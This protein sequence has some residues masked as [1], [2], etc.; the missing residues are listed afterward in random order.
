[1]IEII[2][3][4]VGLVSRGIPE[5]INMWKAR[6]EHKQQI[7]LMRVQLEI[8]EKLASYKLEE[9]RDTN[10]T[11]EA[12]EAMKAQADAVRQQMELTGIQWVDAW[13]RVIR[14]GT[15]SLFVLLYLLT[16]V[17]AAMV[18]FA[19]GGGA[20]N[21]LLAIWSDD[22]DKPVLIAMLN[23]WFAGRVLDHVKR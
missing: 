13:N 23:F 20:W 21:A 8:Q 6:N 18:F 16:K 7:E 19:Q 3:A 14:P 2:A 17:A 5:L 15:F 22:F 9:V 12:I 1:M 4:V 11:N 10:R